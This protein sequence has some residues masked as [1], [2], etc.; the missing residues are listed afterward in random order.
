MFFSSSKAK[1]SNPG[2]PERQ[3][4]KMQSNGPPPAESGEKKTAATTF[5]YINDGQSY[6]DGSGGG[7]SGVKRSAYRNQ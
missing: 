2:S 4:S 7:A 5:S 6:N 1:N 3:S